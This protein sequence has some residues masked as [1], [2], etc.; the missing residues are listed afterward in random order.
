[1]DPIVQ[2]GQDNLSKEIKTASSKV[3]QLRANI[4]QIWGEIEGEELDDIAGAEL[5]KITDAILAVNEAWEMQLEGKGQEGLRKAQQAEKDATASCL[6][7]QD[8]AVSILEAKFT[9]LTRRDVWS[10]RTIDFEPAVAVIEQA[11][12]NAAEARV[13]YEQNDPT[14]VDRY[15]QA[16]THYRNGFGLADR[17]RLSAVGGSRLFWI[18]FLLPLIVGFVALL[19]A[20]F[21]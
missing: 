13:L 9:Q 19:V 15:M 5:D 10:P 16:F 20:F 4:N 7:V 11:R 8:K 2:Q 14:A 6:R 3:S 21:K 1:M 17:R 12:T 18:A